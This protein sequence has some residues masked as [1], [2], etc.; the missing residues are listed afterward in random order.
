MRAF[1][2]FKDVIEWTSEKMYDSCYEV[3]TE[4]WQG[5]DIKQDDRFAMIEILNHSFTCQVSPNLD[6][7][8]EQIRPNVAWADEHFQERVGGIPLNPPP[9][10]Q[11]WP[12]AQ[13]NNAEFGGVTKFSHTYPERI[14]PKYG[15][16]DSETWN[17]KTELEGI[18]FKYGDFMDV[19][20]LMEKEPFTRQAFLPIWFPE[21]TGVVHGERVP[22][23]VAGTL[24]QTSTG[25]K[26]IENINVGELVMTHKGRFRKVQ[27]L[28]SSKY[29]KNIIKIKTENVNIP[30][31]T[32]IDHP[33]L[34]IRNL[35]CLPSDR[36]FIWKEEWV[37]AEDIKKGD[38]VVHSFTDEINNIEYSGDIMRLFG[39]YLSEGEILFDKRRGRNVPK[40]LRFNM[41]TLD[42]EKG[43]IDDL[44]YIIKNELGGDVKIK[45]SSKDDDKKNIR[46]YFHN[47]EFATLVHNTFGSK[48]YNKIIT[49]SILKADPELQYQ[50]LIGYTRGDGSYERNKKNIE[51]TSISKSI[52]MGLRTICMRNKIN[53]SIQKIGLRK[54]YYN[55]RLKRVIK[56][57]Y[58]SYKI[59]FSQGG[60]LSRDFFNIEESLNQRSIYKKDYIKNNR[61][62]SK[63]KNIE[64][65]DNNG[66][67]VFNLQVEDDNSYNIINC[68]VHNCTIGYHFIRRFDWIHV[69]YYIRSCDYFRHFRDDIYLCARKLLWLLDNLKKRDPKTWGHVKPGMLTMHICSLHAFKHE[70]VLLKSKKNF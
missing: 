39:Y 19:V 67:D 41:S 10:H 34:I 42:K 70:K 13:K 9:S 56:P 18:R 3:H 48:S 37:R 54:P 40:T 2:N 33:F 4:K 68:S 50:L 5:K 62:I 23:F 35:G 29:S 11:R 45:Y 46:I 17:D 65:L 30:I 60:R 24:V 53:T 20:N 47:R 36:N 31:E 61:S 49:E 16:L 8:R 55:K 25:Y 44:V 57:N 6:V 28:F 51:C 69:V 27:K 22:C 43:Y 26:E 7:L 1:G 38:Y 14:W 66:T 64:L 59:V 21:D 63:V 12:Y 58:P 15:E 52:I 32:T